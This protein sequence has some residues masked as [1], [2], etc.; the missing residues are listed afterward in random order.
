MR[1]SLIIPHYDDPERLERL[2]RSVPVDRPDLEVLLVDDC[3]PDQSALD[4]LKARWSM[5]RWL[6]TTRNSGA[7]A[8][9]NVGLACA[10]GE[11]LVFADSDDEFL[12]GAF[13]LFDQYVG[14]DDE[15]VYFLAEAV[16]EVD[17]SPS[18]RSEEMN[19]ICRNYFDMPSE[20]TIQS[21]MLEHV[22]PWAKVYSRRLVERV[23]TRFEEARVADDVAFNVLTA[24]QAK[25]VCAV[26]L[27]VYRVFS[28]AGSL[29]KDTTPD[30]FL[31]RVNVYARLATAVKPFGLNIPVSGTGWMLAS[32]SYGPLTAYRVCRVCLG[33]DLQIDFSRI[34]QIS[35]WNRFL[36]KR[37]IERT[38]RRRCRYSGVKK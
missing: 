13:D 25:H 20:A 36:R 28:R 24:V 27:P 3:S 22:V 7:A 17:G 14:D 26:P 6:S 19:R 31:E 33:S 38:E 30:A 8:A 5:I 10:Q 1:Y 12:F 34:I 9:R 37:L 18:K 23:G 35:R 32:L 2:L 4:S 15:L 29:T 16:Q 21:L 11:R